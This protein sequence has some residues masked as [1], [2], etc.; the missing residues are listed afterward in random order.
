M[1]LKRKIYD[2]L[3]EWKKE[4]GRT[5]LLIEGARRI[6]KSTIVE[7][8]AK[9]E[10]SSYLVAEIDIKNNPTKELKR[11]YFINEAIKNIGKKT[12]RGIFIKRENEYKIVWFP[13]NR[14]NKCF[15]N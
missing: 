4:N 8:F 11:F 6:G 15:G 5:A 9:K 10:Y 1:I 12:D 3:V 7:E 13:K 2:N 14:R